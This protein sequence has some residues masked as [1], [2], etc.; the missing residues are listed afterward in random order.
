MAELTGF[1]YTATYSY[2]GTLYRVGVDKV[3]GGSFG[4]EYTNEDWE[5]TVLRGATPV[6][7]AEALHISD[8]ATHE[9]A[10]L[11]ALSWSVDEDGECVVPEYAD[12]IEHRYF[13]D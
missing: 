12:R 5:V 11:E 3:G 2:D 7:I 8:T 13:T 9:L 10:A 6:F 4:V 1:D